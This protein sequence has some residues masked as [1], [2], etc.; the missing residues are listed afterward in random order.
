ML[1]MGQDEMDG[2]ATTIRAPLG[3]ANNN[4]AEDLVDGK[5]YLFLRLILYLYLYLNLFW[6]L[7]NMMALCT[8]LN[9][10]GLIWGQIGC[11]FKF[12]NHG[13]QGNL[14]NHQFHPIYQ[15]RLI[16]NHGNCGNPGNHGNRGNHGNH[17][18]RGNRGNRV[19]SW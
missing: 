11:F 10:Y 8:C 4:I 2:T 14:G 7:P 13:N 16:G 17:G 1:W 12:G 9:R 3:G 18:N 6:S 19:K 15:A 5:L